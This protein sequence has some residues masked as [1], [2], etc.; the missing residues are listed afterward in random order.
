LSDLETTI[1]V[2][3]RRAGDLEKIIEKIKKD[4]EIE[5]VRANEELEIEREKVY[6]L[7][8]MEIQMQQ[9]KKKAEDL[10]NT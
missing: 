7:Q 2:S 5:R 4:N 3:N 9:F 8:R 10:S 1:E 6:Q